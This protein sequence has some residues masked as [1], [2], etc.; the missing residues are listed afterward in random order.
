MDADGP[1]QI[2][3][4]DAL[5]RTTTSREQREALLDEFER[6]GLKGTQ[7]A[8]LVGVKY[9]TFASW[10]QKRQHER[11]GY[12]GSGLVQVAAESGSVALVEAVAPR[13]SAPTQA[14]TGAGLPIQLPGGATAL[15]TTPQ[16]ARL[17]AELLNAL[18]TSC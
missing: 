14:H 2:V 9:P 18:R 3:K 13:P 5:G 7:F 8:R 11:G 12:A 6:S 16:Q 17:A 1:T 15:V 4:R 10:V